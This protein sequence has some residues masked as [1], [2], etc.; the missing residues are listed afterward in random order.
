MEIKSKQSPFLLFV[1]ILIGFVV[2][3]I[4][5]RR[6]TFLKHYPYFNTPLIDLRQLLEAINNYKISGTY[7]LDQNAINQ[8]L[9]LVKLYHVLYDTYGLIGIKGFLFLCDLV[10]VVTQVSLIGKIYKKEKDSGIKQSMQ[11]LLI[12]NPLAMISPAVHNLAI[13]KYMILS[14]VMHGVIS[15]K[16]FKGILSDIL[17]GVSLYVDP[18]L[19]YVLVPVR[20]ISN[21]ID[22]KSYLIGVNVIKS[23]LIWAIVLIGILSIV[24]WKADIRNY[25]NILH[26]R[27]HSENI[28]IYW[29]IFVEIFK[30]HV[31][32]YQNLYLLFLVILASQVVLDLSLYTRVVAINNPKGKDPSQRILCW[33]FMLTLYVSKT[34]FNIF[35]AAHH[36]DALSVL[37]RRQPSASRPLP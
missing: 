34:S 10:A 24:E 12:L 35:S 33:S 11:I 3:V 18:S 27:D 32:F 19:I 26:V 23:F 14:L 28:G 4:L 36:F 17:C 15:N 8:P 16:G 13:V 31:F 5:E 30:Q 20:L 1:L 25:V 21:L 9:V 37:A 22:H 6:L 29:Y 2:R 7:F